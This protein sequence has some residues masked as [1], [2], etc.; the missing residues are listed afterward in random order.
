MVNGN[1][2]TYKLSHDNKHTADINWNSTPG[3]IKT[4]LGSLSSIESNKLTVTYANP[5]TAGYSTSTLTVDA[6]GGTFTLSHN[7]NTT[8]DLAWDADANAI[9][10]A[11]N[12]L[13]SIQNATVSGTNG[14]FQVKIGDDP[15]SGL[16]ASAENLFKG[17]QGRYQI[18]LDGN[19][20]TNLSGNNQDL[21]YLGSAS[22]SSGKLAV[23]AHFG[24]FKLTYNHETTE[25]IAANANANQI[26]TELAKLTDLANVKVNATGDQF[27]IKLNSQSLPN[28]S[29]AVADQHRLYKAV[30]PV[31]FR[32]V[33]GVQGTPHNDF[34]LGVEGSEE[35]FYFADN[36]GND[37][38]YAQADDTVDFAGV[39]GAVSTT[40]NAD[41]SKKYT[42]DNSSVTVHG[43]LKEENLNSSSTAAAV[44]T[45]F[46]SKLRGGGLVSGGD[47][48]AGTT[49]VN[50]TASE[51]DRLKSEVFSR[52]NAVLPATSQI[53]ASDLSFSINDL[54]AVDPSLVANSGFDSASNRFEVILDDDAAGLGWFIDS[55]PEEDS[56]FTGS[57][58]AGMD[59]LTVMMHEVG[60][61]LG[62]THS[63]SSEDGEHEDELMH[64]DLE[65]GL[66]R[67]P[68]SENATHDLA[69][70]DKL[71]AGLDMFGN[72]ASGLGTAVDEYLQ[73]ITTIPFTGTDLASLLGVNFGQYGD[74]ITPRIDLIEAEVGLLPIDRLP[75]LR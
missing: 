68:T 5:G 25:L 6:E 39:S 66:R 10:N 23:D 15:I 67:T 4:K 46:I 49:N 24:S 19:A 9:R 50:A 64:G 14:S 33:E 35:T 2:G 7:S 74:I 13:P 37:V 27:E 65:T 17:T 34:I 8:T 63:H 12:A 16:S 57:G 40:K 20:V 31:T 45:I 36:G 53:T 70:E 26:Q 58:P 1:S 21:Y 73:G 60:H 54:N 29:V 11:L 55:T 51:V 22:Y 28:L 61:F 42:W 18:Q 52:W 32:T 56:E 47:S 59:M 72:W 69:A 43:S 30:T 75:R 62:L 41:G 44:N 3:D 48:G 71:V 38:V